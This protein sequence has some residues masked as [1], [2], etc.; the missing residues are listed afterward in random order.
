MVWESQVQR[1]TQNYEISYYSYYIV[2]PSEPLTAMHLKLV[3]Y[4]GK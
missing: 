1:L 3:L 4:T 2:S